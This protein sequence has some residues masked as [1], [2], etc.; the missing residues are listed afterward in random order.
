MCECFSNH[1]DACN[2]DMGSGLFCELVVYV[3]AHNNLG[4]L[5]KVQG[6]TH[7]VSFAIV[8]LPLC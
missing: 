3:D 7:D 8:C 1:I 6:L 4:N 2:L 5:L